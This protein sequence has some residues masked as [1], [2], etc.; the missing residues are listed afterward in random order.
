[1][2]IDITLIKLAYLDNR[3]TKNNNMRHK[4]RLTRPGPCRNCFKLTETGYSS[5]S[6]V[7]VFP[8]YYIVTFAADRH[9]VKANW[10]ARCAD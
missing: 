9:S 1:M 2:Q 5:I 10:S 3:D 7:H 8:L 6:L 4:E